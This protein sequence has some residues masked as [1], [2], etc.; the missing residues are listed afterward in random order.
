MGDDTGH[1]H[2]AILIKD[3]DPGHNSN[4]YCF[5]FSNS[6]SLFYVFL[7]PDTIL[8]KKF[9]VYHENHGCFTLS[10]KTRVPRLCLAD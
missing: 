8:E 10:T 6:T 4:N 1:W 3:S 2:T 9:G 7:N 5:Q